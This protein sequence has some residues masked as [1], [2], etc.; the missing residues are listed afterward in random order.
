MIWDGIIG[1]TKVGSGNN[2]IISSLEK[3]V[4]EPDLKLRANHKNKLTPSLD[5]RHYKNKWQ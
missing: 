3:K 1:D 2:I 4:L 5:S